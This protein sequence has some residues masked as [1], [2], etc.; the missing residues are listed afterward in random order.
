[1]QKNP[2]PRGI[3]DGI[4]QRLDHD[5]HLSDEE[6]NQGRVALRNF[7]FNIFP[8]RISFQ[9]HSLG[10]EE[11]GDSGRQPADDECPKDENRRDHRPSAPRRAGRARAAVASSPVADL[12]RR[13]ERGEEV[14]EL[15]LESII[16]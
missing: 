1:M 15:I 8:Y 5:V 13:F 2:L 12:K 4:E 7:A 10:R 11:E 6:E 9:R 16:Q 3:N 14:T